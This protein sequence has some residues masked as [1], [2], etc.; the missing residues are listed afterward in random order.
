M[1]GDVFEVEAVEAVEAVKAVKAIKSESFPLLTLWT[2]DFT[3]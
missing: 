1:A 2:F 3:D